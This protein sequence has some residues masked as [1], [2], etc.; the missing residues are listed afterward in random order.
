MFAA[1][2]ISL[3]AATELDGTE[4]F[5]FLRATFLLDS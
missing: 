5:F 1:K 3:N 2:E 4:G